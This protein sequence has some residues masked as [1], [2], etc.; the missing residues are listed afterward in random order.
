MFDT[1]SDLTFIVI[2]NH[3]GKTQYKLFALASMMC[4][5]FSNGMKLILTV[6]GNF[7]NVFP[8]GDKFSLISVCSAYDYISVID[9]NSKMKNT[10]FCNFI[11][12]LWKTCTEDIPQAI[13]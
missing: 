6:N 8:R 4:L 9:I 5:I 13:I 12:V 11:T 7:R 10:R 2:A 3:T 1:Y